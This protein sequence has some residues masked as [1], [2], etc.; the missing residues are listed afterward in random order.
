MYRCRYA[1]WKPKTVF[2]VWTFAFGASG[3]KLTAAAHGRKDFGC[4][5]PIL[6]QLLTPTTAMTVFRCTW[7]YPRQAAPL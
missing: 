2:A 7:I 4:L 1:V 5:I 3:D 6:R